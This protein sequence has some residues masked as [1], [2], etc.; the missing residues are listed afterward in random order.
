MEGRTSYRDVALDSLESAIRRAVGAFRLSADERNDII[1]DALL[2]LLRR[3]QQ[4]AEMPLERRLR[5]AH[6]VARRAVIDFLRRRGRELP[7]S[8]V[9]HESVD[10]HHGIAD[11]GGGRTRSG[12]R[13]CARRS[14]AST[15]G[16]RI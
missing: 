3:R 13:S 8:D 16:W 12:S 15:C 1:Q 11:G 5:Y 4:L 14:L 10:E 2:R 7:A 9:L 6:G